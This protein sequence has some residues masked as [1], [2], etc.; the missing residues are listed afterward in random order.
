MLERSTMDK[1]SSIVIVPKRSNV[2]VTA[3]HLR[4]TNSVTP[5]SFRFAGGKGQLRRTW[6]MSSEQTIQLD[7]FVKAIGAVLGEH[8]MVG[9]SKITVE[10]A[11]DAG[12]SYSL[13]RTPERLIYL[14]D[15][16]N[17]DKD[18]LLIELRDG[19][20]P[21][22]GPLA[23]FSHLFQS[24]RVKK[25]KNN[26]V[27]R[28]EIR[29]DNTT[30]QIREVSSELRKLTQQFNGEVGLNLTPSIISH[31]EPKLQNLLPRIFQVRSMIEQLQSTEQSKIEDHS[32]QIKILREMHAVLADIEASG[33]SISDITHR[34]K[35]IEL[36]LSD[37]QNRYPGLHA[38]N[39]DLNWQEGFQILGRI[40]V[41]K[42]VVKI[43]ADK[44]QEFAEHLQKSFSGFSA[45]WQ[46]IETFDESLISKIEESLLSIP[47]DQNINLKSEDRKRNLT[48]FD[49][50]KV[51]DQSKENLPP[52]F[53]NVS[54][55]HSTSSQRQSIL[56]LLT[57]MQS[58]TQLLDKSL[59]KF[60]DN[61][62]A[63]YEAYL[64]RLEQL[65][66]EWVKFSE[67]ASLPSDLTIETY[68]QAYQALT[69]IK[70]L[71]FEMESID[72]ILQVRKKAAQRLSE[73]VL[74]WRKISHSQKQGSASSLPMLI[75]EAQSYMRYLSM[76]EKQLEENQARLE[77]GR[78]QQSK[79]TDLKQCLAS[80][81][82]EWEECFAKFSLQPIKPD[83]IA[84]SSQLASVIS[85]F[86]GKYD[87]LQAESAI[88]PFGFYGSFF[89]VWTLDDVEQ[90]EEQLRK[91]IQ[92]AAANC[93]HLIVVPS[94][95]M[96]LELYS[97]GTGKILEIPPSEDFGQLDTNRSPT[98][99]THKANVPAQKPQTE[100]PKNQPPRPK[101]LA[102]E[103][104]MK[105]L[106]MLQ[107]K[108]R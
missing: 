41:A 79:I 19:L 83:D 96:A 94:E 51:Q 22:E 42:R 62:E 93:C 100:I 21:L 66:G 45:E 2:I 69:Q 82:T 11:D 95:H 72:R 75:S 71:N 84:S 81:E 36:T 61:M 31:L 78:F 99:I 86:A 33:L 105:T 107:V 44:K 80:L 101:S 47:H 63:L 13:T 3:I 89:N 70:S 60:D 77:Q 20:D 39:I 55:S 34:R 58:Q 73:L 24:H 74:D 12:S 30:R 50:F 6:I 48:W 103:Q 88:V 38:E 43:L 108:R 14:K 57:K 17:I 25:E 52:T 102:T 76:Y 68:S 106:E 91:L 27:A 104:L 59:L 87:K 98:I 46:K 4:R 49:K 67:N 53:D 35:N 29:D 16:K 40:Q 10:L 92:K 23:E 37:L 5:E 54:N 97:F 1:A 18:R 85:Y 8:S 32:T 56:A 15:G 9:F 64:V 90:T 7:W 65:Q 26:F 28:R